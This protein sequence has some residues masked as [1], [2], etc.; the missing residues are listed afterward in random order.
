[1]FLFLFVFLFEL[2][3][4]FLETTYSQLFE[5][6]DI[7]L[8][9]AIPVVRIPE[10]RSRKR[11]ATIKRSAHPTSHIS[12]LAST[13]HLLSFI[14]HH[15]QPTRSDTA[16]KLQVTEYTLNKHGLPPS[17]RINESVHSISSH[18][19]NFCFRIHHK[20]NIFRHDI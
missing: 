5:T 13:F 6:E 19:S 18:L 20:V 12:H 2:L 11:Q 17:L 14:H 8:R 1:V 3:N 9:P 4:I 10:K 7:L 16:L 15:D